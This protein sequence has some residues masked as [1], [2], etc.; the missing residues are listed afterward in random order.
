MYP[1]NGKTQLYGTR[2][3]A[4]ETVIQPD[5]AALLSADKRLEDLLTLARQEARQMAMKYESLLNSVG[6]EDSKDILKAM[7]LDGLKHL[8]LLREVGFTIFGSTDEN[9]QKMEPEMATDTRALLEE[10]LFSEIDDINFYRDLLFAMPEEDLWNAFFEI[11]TDKQ[12]HT[13]AL[14]H[15][16]AKYFR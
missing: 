4:K 5:S 9:M 11:I 10:L 13:A 14:N 15:L 7:Y 12:N 8:R 3:R 16:Y 1:Y 6:M 2:T